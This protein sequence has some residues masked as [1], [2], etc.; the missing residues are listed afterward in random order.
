MATP[1]ITED[2]CDYMINNSLTPT[3][4]GGLVPNSGI[5][6]Y[7]VVEFPGLENI[8]T[9]GTPSANNTYTK[10]DQA[11]IQVQYRHTSAHTALTG[12]LAGADLLDGKGSITINTRVYSFISM[13]ARP[14]IIGRE[15]NGSLVYAADFRVSVIR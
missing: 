3:T 7:A 4:I 15:E 11:M 12:I 9:H 2:I 6:Q 10:L 1:A 8:K 13:T 14:R 5:N